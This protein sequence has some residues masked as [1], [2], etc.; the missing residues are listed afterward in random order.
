MPFELLEDI[1]IADA[2][3]KLTGKNL[4][5][6]IKSSFLAL[7]D[8]VVN[9]ETVDEKHQSIIEIS[10]SP[11][12]KLLYGFLEEIVYLIDAESMIYHSCQVKISPDK[13]N[14]LYSLHCY[15]KGEK[16]D[17][18]KHEMRTDVKAVTYYQF[19][20]KKVADGWEA[21]V[22]FDL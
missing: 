12:D 18:N 17:Y 9:V 7:M 4:E 8:C 3:Y 2:C 21:R 22:T 11:A 10:N 19:Y 1:A 16:I 20:V 5:E 14:N 15:L 13:D 6:L